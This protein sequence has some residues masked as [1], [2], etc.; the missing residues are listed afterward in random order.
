MS[1]IAA[2]GTAL[3]RGDGFRS[4]LLVGGRARLRVHAVR[5][6][7]PRG[8]DLGERSQRTDGGGR[9]RLRARAAAAVLLAL[10]LGGRRAVRPRAGR[11]PRP[12]LQRTLGAMMVVTA[13]AIVAGVDVSFDQ[14]VA[15]HIPDVNLTAS[16]EKSHAVE[17][18]LHR[19]HRPRREVR[20]RV[21]TAGR[22]APRNASDG[23]L[24]ADAHGLKDLGAA[25]EFTEP[26]RLVQ[27]AAAIDAAVARRRCAGTWCWWTSGPTR[28]STASARSPT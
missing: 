13:F 26:Q 2:L 16:L 21:A 9:D 8:G 23:D 7:D 28:A 4:G 25:P 5:R 1:R 17:G 20:A 22:S 14:Y 6:P 15:Q 12:A 27:H 18:R 11:G 19:D 3:P 10:T 24:L